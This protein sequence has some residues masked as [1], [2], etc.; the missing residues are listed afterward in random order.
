[1]LVCLSCGNTFEEPK[2][3]TEDR[4]EC[5]GFPAY[6]HLVGSPC[7]L[8]DYTET[9]KCDGCG[10]WITSEKYVKTKNGDRLCENCFVL[11]E[12]GDED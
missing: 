10:E 5:F 1:M 4:G 12:L 9:Y 2:S 8:G 7:C 11:M 3:W 6:E